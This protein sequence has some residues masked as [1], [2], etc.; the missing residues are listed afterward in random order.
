MAEGGGPLTDKVQ[1]EDGS[2]ERGRKH[3]H[4]R[5]RKSRKQEKLLRNL[6]WLGGGLAAGLPLLAAML[7]AMSR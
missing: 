2:R 5:K 1:P 3:R 6:V 4:K 7:Y